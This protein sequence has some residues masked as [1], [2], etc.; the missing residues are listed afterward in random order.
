MELL[1]KLP[2]ATG[3]ENPEW[4][5][6]NLKYV[7]LSLYMRWH[8][9]SNDYTYVFGVRLTDGCCDNVV[10]PNEKKPEVENAGW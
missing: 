3:T 4:W 2:D 8:R 9:N 1:L 10:R 6:V 7:Y 5:P